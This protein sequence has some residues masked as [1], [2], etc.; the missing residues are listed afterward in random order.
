MSDKMT[1]AETSA[2]LVGQYQLCLML[3]EDYKAG[4]D[5]DDTIN[6]A[7]MIIGNEARKNSQM[8][9]FFETIEARKSITYQQA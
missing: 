4:K 2:W 9:L 6:T 1:T 5:I 8:A 7:L 3:I